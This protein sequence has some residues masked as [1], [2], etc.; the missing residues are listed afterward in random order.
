MTTVSANLW[1]TMDALSI[2]LLATSIALVAVRRLDLGIWVLVFQALILAAVAVSIALIT[3]EGHAWL[4]VGLTLAVKAVVLPL[5]LFRVLRTVRVRRETALVI[6]TKAALLL[7]V[8]AIILSYHGTGLLSLGGAIGPSHHAL[9]VAV[10]VMLIGLG[11]MIGRRKALSQVAGLMVM[12]N[13]VY[14][15]ALAIT[16]GLPLAVEL[17]IAFD[18]LLAVLLLGIFAYRINETF[19]T[20][21]T[22]RLRALRG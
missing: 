20:I 5:V 21:D 4:A 3:G 7:A 2:L 22:D 15:A 12:E 16:M 6:P 13:G 1:A 19:D 8:G 18:L 10:A 11:I 17:G 14:L 9:P